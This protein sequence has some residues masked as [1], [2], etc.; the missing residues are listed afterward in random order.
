[1]HM[2]RIPRQKPRNLLCRLCVAQPQ[3]RVQ[4]IIN[5]LPSDSSS[6]APGSETTRREKS[7]HRWGDRCSQACCEERVSVCM[8]PASENKAHLSDDVSLTMRP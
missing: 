4:S 3:S 6:S 2:R 1:M 8:F 5:S 7:R